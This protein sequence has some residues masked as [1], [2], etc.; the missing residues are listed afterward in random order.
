MD[1]NLVLVYRVLTIGNLLVC[2]LCLNVHKPLKNKTQQT[3]F[4]KADMNYF[5]FIF[6]SKC[7]KYWPDEYSLKEYGVMRVRNVKE[8]AAHDYTLRE[9]KLSKV[10]QVST[11]V[12]ICVQRVPKNH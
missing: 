6:Q 12:D 9:L 11:S 5:C 1:I 10:G 2:R 8:S 4:L 7:V 3:R